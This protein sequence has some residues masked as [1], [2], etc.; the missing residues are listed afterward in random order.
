[1][2]MF[3]MALCLSM[4]GVA[5]AALAFKAATRPSESTQSVQPTV[6]VKPAVVPARFF[7][8]R[9]LPMVPAQP[10]VPIEVLLRQI[11]DHVRLEQ[12]AAESFV[13]F[14]TEALLY[15]KTISPFLN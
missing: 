15:T 11:E 1:M 5:V 4:F 12:A 10:R 2:E 7:S 14:P 6:S 13:E 3:L 8:D 9:V